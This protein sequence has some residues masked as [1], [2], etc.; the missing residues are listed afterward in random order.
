MTMAE[1][2]FDWIITQMERCTA[3]GVVYVVH[4]IVTAVDGTNTASSYGSVSLELPE[5]T[6]MIPYAEL[7]SEI[8]IGWVKDRLEVEEIETA[9]RKQLDEQHSPSRSVGKPWIE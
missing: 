1:T 6:S 5:V 3:D 9:L 4:W 2:T 8:V 7:T